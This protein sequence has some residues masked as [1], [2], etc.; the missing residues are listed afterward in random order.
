MQVRSLVV[1][2]TTAA[3]LAVPAL[4]LAAD[5]PQADHPSA[6]GNPGLTHEPSGT[7]QGEHPDQTS[8]PDG[9][10]NPGATHRPGTPGPK[11]SAKAKARAYGVFCNKES[12][13]HVK[14]QRGTPFSQCVTA[15]A[16]AATGQAT[17][18]RSACKTLSR[19]HVKGQHG[20]PYS[21]C[22]SG[23]AKLLEEQKQAA[24]EGSGDDTSQDTTSTTQS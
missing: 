20:T 10:D 24:Q 12:R 23:A 16:K 5:G 6:T 13:R 7:T 22:V 15:M 11:A 18:P 2:A 17:S 3:L 1:T 4:A 19:K 8:H 9:T 14:G 21:L